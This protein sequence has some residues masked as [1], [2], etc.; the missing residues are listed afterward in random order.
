[1]PVHGNHNDAKEQTLFFATTTPDPAIATDAAEG[2]GVHPAVLVVVGIIALWIGLGFLWNR[3]YRPMRQKAGV[4]VASFNNILGRVLKFIFVE[5]K[6]PALKKNDEGQQT[7]EL[8][9]PKFGKFLVWRNFYI[10]G[11]VICMALSLAGNSGAPWLWGFLLLTIAGRTNK[12]FTQRHSVLTRMFEVAA[13]ELRYPRDANLNPWGWVNIHKWER[14][15]IPGD[16]D[17]KFP[18]AYKS[19]EQKNREN[20]E[21]HFNGTVTD[22]NTWIYKWQ[23]SKSVVSCAPVTHILDYAPYPGSSDGEWNKIPVGVGTDGVVTWDVSVAPH[24]L[25]TGT[26]GG[27]KSTIQRNLI[28]HCIQH[29]DRWRFLGIDVKRVE[30]SPYVKYDPVVMGIATNVEDGVEIIRYANEEMMNRYEQMEG[31]GVNHFKDLPEMPY[32]LMVM[33]DESYMFLAPSGIKTDEGKAEDALKGEASKAIGD[34]ARLGR[35]AGVHLVLATQRPDATVI[36]GELKQNLACRIAAGRMDSIASSMT[37]DNDNAT[38]LPGNIKGRGYIQAFGEGEQFQGYFAPQNW[39]DNWLAGDDP[40][41]DGPAE[42]EKPA[43]KKERKSLMKKKG[44]P[45]E[46]DIE[47]DFANDGEPATPKKKKGGLLAKINAFNE[48]QA[49]DG[50]P[51]NDT[52]TVSGKDTSPKAAKAS[53]KP[54]S[55]RKGDAKAVVGKQESAINVFEDDADP[56][57]DDPF[58]DGSP[59]ITESATSHTEK[60]NLLNQIKEASDIDED[61]F[62]DPFGTLDVPEERSVKSAPAQENKTANSPLIEAE[63]GDDGFS[64]DDDDFSLFSGTETETAESEPSLF[65]ID[66]SETAEEPTPLISLPATDEKPQAAK[67][68]PVQADK[69]LPTLPSLPA[70]KS[71]LPARPGLPARPQRPTL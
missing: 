29:S 22:D 56:F 20:F 64:F 27:G 2:L 68:A 17:V 42:A 35:A 45:K 24:A 32:A 25:V 1:M 10:L 28:F 7:S 47:S 69:G 44:E 57:E 55:L 43:R 31:L 11:F 71:S 39:I 53:I 3:K 14:L 23:S 70:K 37:L 6:Y 33:I 67:P 40:D 51:S 30:L 19:E 13:V 61:D 58:A 26:T 15:T 49:A 12:V 34:I 41:G 54:P 8:K 46:L 5:D 50:S 16:T 38:R 59:L 4:A 21:R 18:P 52:E 63:T 62:V 60:A 48:A 66:E 36:Y 9:Y 65:I